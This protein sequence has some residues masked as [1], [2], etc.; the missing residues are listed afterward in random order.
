[1]LLTPHIA[2]N[3]HEARALMAATPPTA[4]LAALDGRRPDNVVNPEIT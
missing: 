4:S 2:T 3:T 1:M